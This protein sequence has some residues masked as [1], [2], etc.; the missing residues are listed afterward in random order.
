V[1]DVWLDNSGSAGELVEKARALWHERIQPFAHN[2]AHGQPARTEPVLVPS[3][4]SWGDE[5]RRIAARLNTA[6]GHRAVRIDHI[7]STAV[8]GVDAADVIDM[9]VTVPSLEVADE[10]APSLISAG[11]V[12]MPV[13]TDVGKPDARSTVAALDHTN[14]GSLWHKRL[15]WSADPGRPTNVHLRVDGLPGQQFAL[16]FVDWLRANPSVQADYVALKRKAAAAHV[17]AGA[18]AD[19]KEPWFLDAYRRAWEWADTT[20]WRP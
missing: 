1:A 10:L 18:Y 19:A 13:T 14:D 5:G 9:Q 6:C 3:D 11:Y 16:L 12:H 17:D 15:H 2:L 7:G 4:P 8:A 20:G